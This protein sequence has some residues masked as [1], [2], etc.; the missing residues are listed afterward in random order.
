MTFPT[1][2]KFQQQTSFLGAVFVLKS[3]YLDPKKVLPSSS[4]EF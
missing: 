3:A 4:R 1:V 2:L